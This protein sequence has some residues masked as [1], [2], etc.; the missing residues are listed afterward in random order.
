MVTPLKTAKECFDTLTKF[1]KKKASSQEE[2]RIQSK[3]VYTKEENLV[4]I[5]RMKKGRNPFTTKKLIHSIKWI[6]K[7][8]NFLEKGA[9]IKREPTQV[10]KR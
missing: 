4:L 6:K 9:E 3:F 1:F 2:G 10:N 7:D 8:S 5:A